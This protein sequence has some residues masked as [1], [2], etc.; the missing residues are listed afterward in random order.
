MEHLMTLKQGTTVEVSNPDDE[1]FK[2]QFSITTNFITSQYF[3]HNGLQVNS[4]ILVYN[5]PFS[6]KI[7]EIENKKVICAYSKADLTII[8]SGENNG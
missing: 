6:H 1:H 8:D 3:T 5:A 4:D 7:K 2:K